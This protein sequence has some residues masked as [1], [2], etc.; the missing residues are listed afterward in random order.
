[1]GMKFKYGEIEMKSASKRNLDE[2]GMISESY[3][4]KSEYLLSWI[5]LRL[6]WCID[7]FD[8]PPCHIANL[9]NML[10]SL[11]DNKRRLRSFQ[12]NEG[13]NYRGGRDMKVVYKSC[14]RL[15]VNMFFFN[16]CFC[17]L[18]MDAQKQ[19]LFVHPSDHV[20][21]TIHH[22]SHQHTSTLRQ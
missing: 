1:M 12:H 16:F 19:H 2:I 11:R 20:A 7:A 22:M 3:L 14:G 15:Q 4:M 18:C 13:R 6:H 21:E 8:S 9:S 17:L 5:L 10:G